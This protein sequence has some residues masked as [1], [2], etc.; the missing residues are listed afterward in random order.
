MDMKIDGLMPTLPGKVSSDDRTTSGINFK[1]ILN[2]SLRNL[3]DTELHAQEMDRLLAIGEIDN[4]HDVMVASQQ[5]EIALNLALE[6]KTQVIDAY[7]EI[8]R[9]QL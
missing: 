2:E 8:M 7:K 5:A 3:N 9:L 6:I 4:L 1:E